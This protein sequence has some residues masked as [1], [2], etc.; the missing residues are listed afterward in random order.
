MRRPVVLSTGSL[1]SGV[2]ISSYSSASKLSQ[3]DSGCAVERQKKNSDSE[4]TRDQKSEIRK[5]LGSDEYRAHSEQICVST[6]VEILP[7][8]TNTEVLQSVYLFIQ[9]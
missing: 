1:D 8:K 7:Y 6:Q 3:H 2:S 5:K 4:T 9:M